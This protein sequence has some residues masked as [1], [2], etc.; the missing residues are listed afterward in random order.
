MNV[1]ACMSLIRT[2]LHAF[3]YVC[4][5]SLHSSLEKSDAPL[6]IHYFTSSVFLYPPVCV[7]VTVFVC[8]C[9]LPVSPVKSLCSDKLYFMDPVPCLFSLL[10]FSYGSR[11]SHT[12]LNTKTEQAETKAH[13]LNNMQTCMHAQVLYINEIDT[14]TMR[15]C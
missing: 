11:K 1:Y 5:C 3:Y 6:T 4:V 14:R 13:K 12:Q 9:D 7:P 10:D 2:C 15:M 8:V